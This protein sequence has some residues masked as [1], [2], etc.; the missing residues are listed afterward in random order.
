MKATKEEIINSFESA[1]D[2]V[3][4]WE[5]GRPQY[6]IIML[7]AAGEIHG[8][9]LDVG[10]GTGE[11]A[12]YL[13]K[14]GYDVIGVD[15]ASAAISRARKKAWSRDLHGLFLNQDAL[16]LQSLGLKF[17]TIIDS[18]LFHVF[19]DEAR[20]KFVK[21]IDSV[22]RVGGTYLMMCFSEHELPGWGPRRVSQEEI[23]ESFKKGFKINY[24]H[25]AMFQTNHSPGEAKAWLTSFTKI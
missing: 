7:E 23:R 4:G 19:S 21:S 13:V 18:G 3:P 17:D 22:L 25:E 14:Q 11:N 2:G 1:Y 15:V 16:D 8:L 20:K 9:V 6:E 12:L 10:C 24:I 5:V